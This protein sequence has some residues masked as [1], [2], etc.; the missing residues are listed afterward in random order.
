MSQLDSRQHVL[1][2]STL[3]VKGATRKQ[4][5]EVSNPLFQSTLPVKGAT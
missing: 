5:N 3:P 4:T 2:Q 1:I